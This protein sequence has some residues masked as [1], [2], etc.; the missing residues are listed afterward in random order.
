MLRFEVPLGLSVS[1]KLAE[2]ARQQRTLLPLTILALYL[3]VVLRWRDQCELLVGITSHGR[4]EPALRNVIG[5]LAHNLLVRISL[6][7]DDRFPDLLRRVNSE[8]FRALR[9]HCFG[10]ELRF[11]PDGTPKLSFNWVQTKPI[12]VRRGRHERLRD[13]LSIT[14][15]SFATTEPDNE[16]FPW[17]A[18]GGSISA[19]NEIVSLICYQA[20][21]FLP[22]TVARLGRNLVAFSRHLISN[23]DVRILSLNFR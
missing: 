14:P 20:N 6:H 1:E 15:F 8:F 12:D 3:V 10:A 7:R 11:A 5:Y 2:L 4:H 13:E 19:D 16:S 23:P 17:L 21:Q 9:H 18:F 22:T